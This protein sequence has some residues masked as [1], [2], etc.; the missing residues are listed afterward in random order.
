MFSE[1]P[2]PERTNVMHYSASYRSADLLQNISN[3][4]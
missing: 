1:G 3:Y 4:I 2:E